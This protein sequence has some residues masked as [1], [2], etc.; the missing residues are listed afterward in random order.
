MT[1]LDPTTNA[2]LQARAQQLLEFLKDIPAS[3]DLDDAR[4]YPVPA[5]LAEAIATHLAHCGVGIIDQPNRAWEPPPA[6]QG[7][8]LN[9]GKWRD[10]TMENFARQ[11]TDVIGDIFADLIPPKT[12]ETR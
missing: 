8:Y 11:S 5:E 1:P 4:A 3:A 10:L 6:G 2:E 9:P 12:G 7:H